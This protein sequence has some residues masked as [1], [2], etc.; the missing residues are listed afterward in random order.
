MGHKLSNWP[1]CPEWHRYLP[2][3][4]PPLSPWGAIPGP[5]L[6]PQSS[7]ELVL[8]Q[9]IVLCKSQARSRTQHMTTKCPR[10]TSGKEA[11]RS[12]WEETLYIISTTGKSLTWLSEVAAELYMWECQSHQVCN[13]HANFFVSPASSVAYNGPKGI[14]GGRYYSPG[15]GCKYGWDLWAQAKYFNSVLS[16]R[17]A[18]VSPPLRG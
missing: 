6:A 8:W 12:P 14:L 5:T 1:L 10:L 11:F 4:I 7:S 15:R 3:L 17:R 18:R 16:W 2:T 13:Q 9:S